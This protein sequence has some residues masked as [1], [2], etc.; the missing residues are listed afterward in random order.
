MQF[1]WFF[2]Y[3]ITNCTTPCDAVRC[4]ALLLACS[5]I[6]PFYGWFWYNFYDLCS[7]MNTPNYKYHYKI[8]DI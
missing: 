3:K 7:L 1:V 5:V 6:M 2:Y 8:V 4:D